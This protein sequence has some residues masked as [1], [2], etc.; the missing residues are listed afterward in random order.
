MLLKRK[1]RY[2]VQCFHLSH[3]FDNVFFVLFIGLEYFKIISCFCNS[4]YKEASNFFLN[5][6]SFMCN[7]IE[8]DVLDNE[9]RW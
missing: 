3:D 6:K 4:N 1:G 9:L 7:A 8:R 5:L 2:A